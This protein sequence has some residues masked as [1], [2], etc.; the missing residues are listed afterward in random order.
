QRSPRT[1]PATPPAA[2]NSLLLDTRKQQGRDVRQ[3]MYQQ[4]SPQQRGMPDEM[5][6]EY[7]IQLEPPGPQELFRI[8]SEAA[9]MERRRQ[10]A[11]ERLPAERIEFPVE[12]IV[13]GRGPYVQRAFAPSTML[14]EPYYVCY[15]RLFFEDKNTERYGWDLGPIQPILSFAEFYKDLVFL[16]YHAFTNPCRWY[17]CSAGYCLPGD[18]VPLLIYPPQ[19]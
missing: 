14:V 9:L 13:G 5:T 4:R 17:E 8:D 3:I 15:G 19:L 1:P 6:Q 7:S 11:G 18:P 10:K 12:P 2:Q 16:P